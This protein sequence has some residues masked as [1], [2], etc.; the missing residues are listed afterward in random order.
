MPVMH[1]SGPDTFGGTFGPVVAVAPVEAEEPLPDR[2]RTRGDCVDGP[3]PCPWVGCRHHL[4]L[5][6]RGNTIALNFEGEPDEMSETCSLD[7]AGRGETNLEDVGAIW[8]VTGEWI[9]RLELDAK[10]KLRKPRAAVLREFVEDSADSVPRRRRRPVLPRRSR[11]KEAPVSVPAPVEPAL[12]AEPPVWR[13]AKKAPSTPEQDA[14]CVEALQTSGLYDYVL[15][16]C[17]PFHVTVLDL[18]GPRKYQSVAHA[19][20][21]VYVALAE[22]PHV[23]FSSGEIGRMLGGRD[24][25]TVLDGMKAHR[26]RVG[27]V[28]A[29]PAKKAEEAT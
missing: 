29:V 27:E 4:Y 6:A 12:P 20:Q 28:G 16:V 3:R 21:A 17:R 13:G 9:R 18:V 24:H 11:V 26:Q 2:P 22:Y 19:R 10:A 7:V 5:E 8:G 23:R 25:S 1:D 14:A 15:D